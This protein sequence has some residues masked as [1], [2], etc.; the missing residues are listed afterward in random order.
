MDTKQCR[1][2]KGEGGSGGPSISMNAHLEKIEH[3]EAVHELN[4]FFFARPPYNQHKLY[5]ILN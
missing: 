4:R 1:A 3:I 2:R 5:Y